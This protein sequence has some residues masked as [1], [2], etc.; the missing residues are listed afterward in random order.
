V[1]ENTAI[2]VTVMVSSLAHFQQCR[3]YLD[4]MTSTPINQMRMDKHHSVVL[5]GVG[6]RE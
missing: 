6:M 1:A 3:Y 5:L 4:E 2:A